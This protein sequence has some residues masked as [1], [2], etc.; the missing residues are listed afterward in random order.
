MLETWTSCIYLHSGFSCGIN[1]YLVVGGAFLKTQIEMKNIQEEFSRS[2]FKAFQ[3]R[4][5]MEL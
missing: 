1:I 4:L 3:G 5:L 2:I